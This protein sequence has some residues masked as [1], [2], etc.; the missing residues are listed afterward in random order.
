MHNESTITSNL[1]NTHLCA[2]V[3]IINGM[4]K[5]RSSAD[6]L[7][8]VHTEVLPRRLCSLALLHDVML[9]RH[10]RGNLAMCHNSP[11]LPATVSFAY[12]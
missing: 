9:A 7:I 2:D 1:R 4:A 5:T 12:L 11:T 8:T 3:K 6:V 10:H